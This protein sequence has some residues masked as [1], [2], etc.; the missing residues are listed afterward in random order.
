MQTLINNTYEHALAN[1]FHII[2]NRGLAIDGQRIGALRQEVET[3]I[4]TELAEI[5]KAWHC[6]VY[7]G[8]DNDDGT[9]D[10]VNLNA[11]SGKRT[12]LKKL[13][14]LGYKVPKIRKKNERKE[15][16]Y[17]ESTNEL[18][19]QRLYGES[20][21]DT[22]KRILT[23]RELN[24]ILTTYINARLSAGT[25]YS[26]YNVAGT[27]TGRRGSKR[28]IFG[29]GNNAQNFPKHSKLGKRFRRCIVSRKGR[30]FFSVDQISAEDWPVSALAE[31]HPR[32]KQL[33][34]AAIGQ[35]DPHTDLA[36]FIFGL[37]RQSKT[38]KEWKDSIERYLGKKCRHAN[39]YGMRAQQM[40]DQLA[41]QGYSVNKSACEILLQK[42]HEY[43][44]SVQQ[45][46]HS[47]VRQQISASRLLRTPL[48]RERYFFGFRPNDHNYELFNE[49]YSYIPQ[50]VVGD[51]TGL[52]ILYLSSHNEYIVQDGHDSIIQELPDDERELVKVFGQ[53]K[54]AF[55]R[56]ITFHNGITIKIP[57]EAELGYDLDSLIRVKE[58]SEECLIETLKKA[59]EI[60]GESS[61]EAV[62]TSV[63]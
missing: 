1:A 40:S 4:K 44:P 61:Q 8:R 27:V 21:D 62:V 11:T 13:E 58:F 20:G 48:G 30:I 56:D 57:I 16:E 17:K 19:L 18:A 26:N 28:H 5:S 7:V 22:I 63:S 3:D 39:N 33:G 14:S 47:Y 32:L 54:A 59:R 2:D 42:V 46:F 25:L 50:S 53:T 37:P 38:E 34:L 15:I 41:A 51:N 24:K 31:N 43:D 49:A 60:R 9:A 12:L 55:E 29:F 10:S 6:H 23:V 52:A 35:F 45:I 36:C